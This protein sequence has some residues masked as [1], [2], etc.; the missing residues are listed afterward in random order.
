MEIAWGLED[1]GRVEFVSDAKVVDELIHEVGHALFLD[2]T[3]NQCQKPGMSYAELCN[4][5]CK[6]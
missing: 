1:G 2:H 6:G 5:T 3:S 4:F